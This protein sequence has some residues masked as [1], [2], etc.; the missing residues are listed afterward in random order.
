MRA[1]RERLFYG[2]HE[3]LQLISAVYRV[4]TILYKSG[5]PIQ[6]NTVK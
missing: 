4:F 5:G 3:L 2:R 1:E 6:V